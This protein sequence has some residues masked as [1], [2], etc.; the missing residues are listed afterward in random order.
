MYTMWHRW[1]LDILHY[2][3]LSLPK[4][5]LTKPTNLICPMKPKGVT[6]QMKALDEYFWMVVFTLLLNRVHDFA[7]SV[8]HLNRAT[9]QW[10]GTS[11]GNL[12]YERKKQ[13][14]WIVK[15]II[16]VVPFLSFRISNSSICSLF[17]GSC[18]G[19]S[20]GIVFY[21]KWRGISL[22]LCNHDF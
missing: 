3:T 22:N 11:K 21:L 10:K 8:F 17:S 20:A 1:F 12:N 19:Y 6:T 5:N 2:L 16:K 7:N 9:W 15:H 4:A 13:I 18:N 14:Y